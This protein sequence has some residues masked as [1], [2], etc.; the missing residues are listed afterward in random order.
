VGEIC[1][2]LEVTETTYYRWRSQYGVMKAEE[3][4]RLK[5]LQVE[6]ARS[7]RLVA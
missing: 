6:N 7:E 2:C 1:Q 4:R 5:E 3:A